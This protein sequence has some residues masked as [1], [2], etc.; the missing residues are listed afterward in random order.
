MLTLN[1]SHIF[2]CFILGKYWERKVQY[3]F[4]GTFIGRDLRKQTD[5]AFKYNLCNFSRTEMKNLKNTYLVLQV[6][7]LFLW[8]SKQKTLIFQLSTFLFYDLDLWQQKIP[9]TLIQLTGGWYINRQKL[10]LNTKVKRLLKKCYYL[11][12]FKQI[13]P[14]RC[15]NIIAIETPNLT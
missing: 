15:K 2:L 9:K 13:A 8:S 11:W 5:N 3:I 7:I 6:Q 10:N 12:H 14:L 4:W 1:N